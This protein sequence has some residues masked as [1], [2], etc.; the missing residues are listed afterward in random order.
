LK[1]SALPNRVRKFLR[2]LNANV[3]IAF[4]VFAALVTMLVTGVFRS[5][6]YR[7]YDTIASMASPKKSALPITIVGIDEASFAELKQQW[8]WPRSMHAELIKK[9]NAGG[10]AV[11]ALDIVF[12]EASTPSED[13][14][15]AG[16]IDKYRNVVL[17]ANR[18]YT[19]SQYGKQWVRVEPL[20]LFRD[21]G[22]IT[23]FATVPL[24]KDLV[25]RQ[26]PEGRDVLWREILDLLGRRQPGSTSVIS[27]QENRLIGFAGG[28][29]TFPYVSYHEVLNGSS[30]LAADAFQDQ[31]VIVGRD[32]KSATDIRA[33]QADT[34]ATPFSAGTALRTPGAEVHANILESAINGT[35][36]AQASL[37]EQILLLL[38][39]V[40]LAALGMSR[41]TPVRGL[42][43]AAVLVAG[44]AALVWLLFVRANIWLPPSAAVI[45]PVVLYITKNA[46]AFFTE[47][48]HLL[49]T[50]RAFGLYL[51]P[52]VVDQLMANPERLKLGGERREVTIVFT[53]LAG[54]TDISERLGAEQVTSLLNQH[55]T[56]MGRIIMQHK[57][58]LNRFIGDAI[59]AFW[60][61][62]LDDADQYDHA[63]LVAEKMRDD[64]E[65]MRKDLREQGLPEIFIR[66]GINS[67]VAIIGNLGSE[68]RF[69]YTA[70]GDCVNLAARLEGVN[71]LYGTEILISKQTASRL[72][73]QSK[74]RMVDR[75]IVKG[76]TEP[77]DVFTLEDDQEIIS[78]S[79]EGFDAYT[80]QQWDAA[81]DVWR[82]I[83]VRRPDDGVVAVLLAR[84]EQLRTQTLGLAWNGAMALEKM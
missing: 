47:R 65:L 11:I 32:V 40:V 69:D 36:R 3:V 21:A 38:L 24:D 64:M 60:G 79:R 31:V 82:K 53:D 19:E 59:M 35:T 49:E 10:A 34:F 16:A 17:A 81:I 37:K 77:V 67:G 72:K 80:C 63:V 45:A 28:D 8:P 41:W 70:I 27:N 71:K 78:W 51:S 30:R 55:F 5:L 23:G 54:F 50:R 84:V 58:T 7:A 12:P 73:D 6:D 66:I 33:E 43:I 13:A 46:Y 75:I 52:D 76:K 26:M 22:G 18:E 62:P 48:A 74:C 39:L 25:L 4:L 2:T 9:L 14:A 57:G 42:A 61:A 83:L 56:R 68:D 44:I 29:H 20:Q 1:L 15:L